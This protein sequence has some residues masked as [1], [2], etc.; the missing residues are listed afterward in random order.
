MRIIASR[1]LITHSVNSLVIVFQVLLK[2]LRLIVR[3][4]HATITG[5]K[6]ISYILL[7]TRSSEF[8]R[9]GTIFKCK[10]LVTSYL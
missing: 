7:I 3:E 4:V 8:F 5:D 6:S 10:L 9:A 1:I 2:E